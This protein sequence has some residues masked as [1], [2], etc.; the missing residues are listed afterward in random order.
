V[1]V[2]QVSSLATTYIRVPV[3]T[4]NLGTPVNP[5]GYTVQMAFIAALANVPPSSGDWKAASWD[6]TA[7]GG[8]V[9]QCL[10]GPSGGTITLTSGTAYAVWIKIQA[11]PETFVAS[12]GQVQATP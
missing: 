5:T 3:Y 10:V 8:Y 6:T 4:D 1:N 11:N 2:A 12:T 7:Q 9:A